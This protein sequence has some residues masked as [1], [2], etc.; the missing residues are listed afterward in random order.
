MYLSRSNWTY[1]QNMIWDRKEQVL[2][3][4]WT[5]TRTAFNLYNGGQ[6]RACV[7]ARA[8]VCVCVRSEFSYIASYGKLNF[9]SIGIK[10]VEKEDMSYYN[11]IY[12][13]SGRKILTYY[14][15]SKILRV[16]HHMALFRENIDLRVHPK[17]ARKINFHIWG[18]L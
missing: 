12:K 13:H 1:L 9:N 11:S 5:I 18:K 15:W 2:G 16:K 8:C 3:T 7:C 6:W 4:L 17:L 10:V 14:I